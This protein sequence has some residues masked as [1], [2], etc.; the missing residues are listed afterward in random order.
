MTLL[1]THILYDNGYLLT[2]FIIRIDYYI[3][4]TYYRK[5]QKLLNHK[6]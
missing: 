2:Y 5:N 6:Y 4:L 3:I 1:F